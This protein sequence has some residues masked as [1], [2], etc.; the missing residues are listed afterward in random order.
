MLND[1][2]LIERRIIEGTLR[3]EPFDNGLKWRAS[4]SVRIQNNISHP[5]QQLREAGIVD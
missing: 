2:N 1:R 4:M 5:S 3:S